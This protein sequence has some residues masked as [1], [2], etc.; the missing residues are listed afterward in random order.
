MWR[1]LVSVR[2]KHRNWS[3]SVLSKGRW[4]Q[5]SIR[6]MQDRTLDWIQD[7]IAC[8]VR[9]SSSFL[10]LTAGVR[11][12]A[13]FSKKTIIIRFVKTKFG[14]SKRNNRMLTGALRQL[15]SL[16]RRKRRYHFF[17]QSR[18]LIARSCLNAIYNFRCKG[19][20]K[21]GTKT[22]IVS[23][24]ETIPALLLVPS[25]TNVSFILLNRRSG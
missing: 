20:L 9:L 2:S 12:Q 18:A 8:A 3:G 21:H 1:L 7:W 15:S 17:R 6:S 4:I 16:G 14:L 24:S 25:K 22:K 19:I 23:S 5:S 10:F 13:F 11:F